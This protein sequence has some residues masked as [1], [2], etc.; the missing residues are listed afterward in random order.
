MFIV[1]IS[2]RLIGD[3]ALL[4]APPEAT[5]EDIEQIRIMLGLHESLPVQFYRYVSG[6]FQLDFGMSLRWRI[7]AFELW[8]SRLPNTLLL[9]I[10]VTVIGGPLGIFLGIISALK[11]NKWPDN[12]SRLFAFIGMS[13]PQFWVAIMLVMIFAVRLDWF[14][15]SGFPTSGLGGLKYLILP[16]VA[17]LI[18]GMAGG[19]RFTRTVMLDVLDSE[20]IKMARIKG[21]PG[22]S[23]TLRHA[24]RNA[25]M[26]IITGMIL[27]IPSLL[28]GALLIEM[29]FNWP[30][31]GRLMI[32]AV[33][34]RDYPLVQCAALLGS[35]LFLIC[36]ILV[37]IA[38]VYIDPRIRYR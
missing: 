9:A 34:T 13:M 11:V 30:G 22:Y 18:G 36:S 33:W 3:P 8:L 26:P 31:I 21:V 32:E 2:V 29:I 19:I 14:P 35:G 12:L 16:T 28:T 23:V 17:M 1:F 15:T 37:D 4:M 25:S 20:Y 27:G 6:I 10:P 7:P 5:L 24:F 38:Y